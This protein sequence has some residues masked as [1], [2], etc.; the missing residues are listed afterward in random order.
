MPKSKSNRKKSRRTAVAS[1]KKTQRVS[2]RSRKEKSR[3]R[4]VTR[5]GGGGMRMGNE[6]YE[7]EG[8]EYEGDERQTLFYR[9]VITLYFGRVALPDGKMLM[10]KHGNVD[11]DDMEH[12]LINIPCPF[13]RQYAKSALTKD[14]ERKDFVY[15]RGIAD[16][17]IS[18][19]LIVQKGEC[20]NYPDV[21]T[22]QLIC[23]TPGNADARL[24]LGLYCYALKVLDYPMG[25]LELSGA[26][27][28]KAGYCLYTKFGFQEP[29]AESLSH[30]GWEDCPIFSEDNLPM[31]LDVRAM[32]TDNIFAV[33]H[34]QPSM[35][36]PAALCE[37]IPGEP[38]A[39][40]HTRQK[41]LVKELKKMWKSKGY[42]DG[43]K[44]RYKKHNVTVD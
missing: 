29:I 21:W 41:G 32:N 34:G 37:K 2:S 4:P 9:D 28:N 44:R 6:E 36:P 10:Y 27:E 3:R 24:L 15:L 11:E 25:L 43:F 38:N 7:E 42:N 26:Y 19:F 5:G 40:R 31:I 20:V 33:V 8:E 14:E 17:T 16:D 30:I 18:A 12:F 13:F 22:V 23:G 35:Y 39:A 1:K